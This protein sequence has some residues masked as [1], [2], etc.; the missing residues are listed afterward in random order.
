MRAR[1]QFHRR[2]VL[3]LERLVAHATRQC[4][5]FRDAACML[6][7]IHHRTSLLEH[8]LLLLVIFQPQQSEE[9]YPGLAGGWL[10]SLPTLSGW[11]PL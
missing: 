8:C 4:H 1:A 10:A 6:R 3:I 7:A 9:V 11:G 5:V 2:L